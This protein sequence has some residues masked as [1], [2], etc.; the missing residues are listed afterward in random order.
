MSCSGDWALVLDTVR[1]PSGGWDCR[2]LTGILIPRTPRGA[3]MYRNVGAVFDG[4]LNSLSFTPQFLPLPSVSLLS[5]L[6]AA[7]RHE[8]RGLTSHLHSTIHRE[9]SAVTSHLPPLP[10]FLSLS[11]SDLRLA[12]GIEGE[13][14]ILY[15]LYDGGRWQGWCYWGHVRKTGDDSDHKMFFQLLRKRNVTQKCAGRSE[16][17]GG[18]S[19]Y[20]NLDLSG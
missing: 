13:L 8:E 4:K 9:G 7:I 14:V 6:P 11:R 1:R 12:G 19:I 15:N 20:R 2:S 17:T 10:S 18:F 16:W 5:S 3:K